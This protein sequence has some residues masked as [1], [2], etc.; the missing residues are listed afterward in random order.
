MCSL[1][2]SDLTTAA[3]GSRNCTVPTR[4]VLES[5]PD[6]YYIK[7]GFGVWFEGTSSVV[8]SD[9]GGG[10][11]G[12][13]ANALGVSASEREAF[14][15]ILRNDV[16]RGFNVTVTEVFV[17]NITVPG[18]G[19]FERRR[20]GI[21]TLHSLGESNGSGSGG[22][23][24]GGGSGGAKGG[25]QGRGISRGALAA[26]AL[27]ASGADGGGGGGSGRDS[28]GREGGDGSNR[29]DQ[30]SATEPIIGGGRSLLAEQALVAGRQCD[31]EPS[32]VA[33]AAVLVV[34]QATEVQRVGV[35][36]PYDTIVAKVAA[37]EM[38]VAAALVAL[39][40]DP[41]AFFLSTLTILGP[42]VS[43]TLVG[44]T[45]REEKRPPPPGQFKDLFD[46]LPMHPGWLF[47]SVAAA[48][49]LYVLVPRVTKQVITWHKEYKARMGRAAG[50]VQAG[51]AHTP[52]AISS[53][54]ARTAR[55]PPTHAHNKSSPELSTL[56][57]QLL[58]RKPCSSDPRP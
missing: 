4:T 54:L 45:T 32:C 44:N 37:A 30:D 21:L 26:A 41:D 23:G 3:A 8:P 19:V 43:A 48:A 1:C 51:P 40:A 36:V 22:S 28:R 33:A 20:R 58:T 27:A 13:L 15:H 35:V 7:L 42:G 25:G 53:V 52:P 10:G 46:Y 49:G 55:Q 38:R 50:D 16:A 47:G 12:R 6:V 24:G 14:V 11:S 31:A 39:R 2:P 34:V 57:P 5:H 17:S 56:N 9:G 29:G 18:A